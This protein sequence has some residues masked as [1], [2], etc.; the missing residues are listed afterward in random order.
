MEIK[1]LGHLVLYVRNI[2]RSAA[3]YGDVLGWKRL[4]SAA[5]GPLA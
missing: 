1:E 5:G 4:T 3:F 2:E